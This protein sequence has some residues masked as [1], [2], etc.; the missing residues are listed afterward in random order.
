[1]IKEEKIK[2]AEEM[3]KELE[4][5]S[6]HVKTVDNFIQKNLYAIDRDVIMKW[7]DLR[8]YLGFSGPIEVKL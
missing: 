1:M 8:G 3:Q 2:A 6:P 5:L 7:L 4:E